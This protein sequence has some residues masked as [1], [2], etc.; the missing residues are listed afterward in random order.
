MTR[1]VSGR[2]AAVEQ[3]ESWVGR[4]RQERGERERHRRM[5]VD[6]TGWGNGE[7]SG[8][9]K[10]QLKGTRKGFLFLTSDT[11]QVWRVSLCTE[12]LSEVVPEKCNMR[13]CVCKFCAYTT[14][15]FSI[16]MIVKPLQ[17]QM[18]LEICSSSWNKSKQQTC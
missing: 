10:A 3:W 18:V 16:L 5:W 8:R 4:R 17:G 6:R 15:S 7:V 11:W 2:A 9:A 14:T 12:K 1:S 13:G